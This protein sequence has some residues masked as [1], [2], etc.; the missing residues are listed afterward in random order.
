MFKSRLKG[1]TLIELIVVI[2]IVAILAAIVI[3]AVNPARQFAQARNTQRRS[4]I[5]ALL[6]AIH[7]YAADPSNNG[8]LPASITGLAA[9]TPTF[10]CNDTDGA[11]PAV[12]CAAGAIDLRPSLVSNF[13]SDLPKD[14]GQNVTNA[15]TRYRVSHDANNRITIDSPDAELGAVISITR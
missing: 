14:P 3:V 8:V 9:D 2:G 4:D 5:T 13:L 7:Q 6:D 15:N 10:I 11:G 12:V 1:F